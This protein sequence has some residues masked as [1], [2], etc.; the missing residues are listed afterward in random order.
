[1]CMVYGDKRTLIKVYGFLWRQINKMATQ[2]VKME[3]FSDIDDYSL[4]DIVE[5]TQSVTTISL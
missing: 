4:L 1:M 3:D 2:T 5:Q